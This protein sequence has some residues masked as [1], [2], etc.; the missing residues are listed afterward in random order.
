LPHS[1]SHHP[2][3]GSAIASYFDDFKESSMLLS[4]KAIQ[5][6][7]IYK[8]IKDDESQIKSDL[9]GSPQVQTIFRS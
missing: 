4:K 2:I 6:Y 7:Q 1:G 9:S 5:A 3:I 8:T